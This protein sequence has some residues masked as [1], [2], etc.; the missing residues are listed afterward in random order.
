MLLNQFK[1][2]ATGLSSGVSISR[3]GSSALRA[4]SFLVVRRASKCAAV[5]A[6][7]TS[8]EG[9]F[10]SSMAGR[11]T[12]KVAKVAD[13]A[14]HYVDGRHGDETVQYNGTAVVMKKFI[15]DGNLN[16]TFNA[17]A[18]IIDDKSD[19]EGKNIT[20]QLVSSEIDPSMS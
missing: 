7:S 8:G 12:S 14:L 10:E 16:I 6:T 18:D 13:A 3:A 17:D 4:D 11:V 20:V 19:I 1:T 5:R 15:M 2:T 9:W